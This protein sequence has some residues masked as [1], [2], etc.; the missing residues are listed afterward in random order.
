[1]WFANKQG[2]AFKIFTFYLM[3]MLIIQ[4][5]TTLLQ[6]MSINNIYLSHFYFILQFL[7]LSYFYFE[8]FQIDFHKKIVKIAVPVCITVLAI[9]YYFNPDLF[10]KFN[11]FEIFITSFLII[12]FSMFHFYTILNE[13]KR[14]Y[15]INIGI[16]AYLFGSAFLFI[17]GNLMNSLNGS[18]GNITWIINSILY[19]VYQVYIFIEF[20]GLYFDKKSK[21]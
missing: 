19:I 4:L 6:T 17:S 16:F 2:K 15:Y 10:Y 9:Q 7:I 20:K 18:F 5:L 12:I 21:L 3:I 11:Y 13:K 1:M 14:Y 8:I